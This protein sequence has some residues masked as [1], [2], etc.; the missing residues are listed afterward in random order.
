M[1]A[2]E[3]YTKI[4]RFRLQNPLP[5]NVDGELHHIVPKSCGG[6]DLQDNLIK[7]TVDE[8]VRCHRLLPEIYTTGTEHRSMVYALHLLAVTR[9][10]T[11]LS[12]EEILAARSEMS[13]IMKQKTVPENVRKKISEHNKGKVFS[14]E[15]RRHISEACKGRPSAFKGKHHNPESLRKIKEARKRQVSP[16][17]GKRLS[18]EARRKMSEAKKKYWEKR[19]KGD[20]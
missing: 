9:N 15:R 17:K 20:I 13:E 5:E 10:N 1:I 14:A 6:K 16:T 19:R 4:I 12:D 7:L 11:V 2:T 3:E 8:H 18:P